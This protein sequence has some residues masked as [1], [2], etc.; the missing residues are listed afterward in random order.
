MI[1]KSMAPDPQNLG[2]DE[3]NFAEFPLALLS[4]RASSGV[5]LLE[6][7]DT[8]TDRKTRLPVQRKVRVYGAQNL[9]LPTS[10][11]ADV[12]IALLKLTKDQNGCTSRVVY[13]SRYGLLKILGWARTG[14]S[15]QRLRMAIRRWLGVYIEYERA[16]WN[17]AIEEWADVHFHVL[18]SA[19]IYGG[20]RIPKGEQADLPYSSFTWNETVF[21]SFQAG[22]IKNLDMSFYL[23]LQSA[24]SKQMYRFLDKHFWQRD[25]L[26]YDLRDFAFEHIG[27]SRKYDTGKIKEKLDPHIRELEE[28]EFLEPMPRSERYRQIR[29]GEWKIIL[30]RHK[31]HPQL[32][33]ATEAKATLHEV[34]PLQAQ[35]MARGIH[36]EMARSLLAEYPADHITTQIETFDTLM[37][38]RD[39]RVSKNPPGWLVDAIRK[40]YHKPKD[41]ATPTDKKRRSEDRI[42]AKKR[43][44][45]LEAERE[46]EELV[47]REQERAPLVAYW[48]SLSAEQQKELE[49][50]ALAAA[51]PMNRERALTDSKFAVA[52]KQYIIDKYIQNILSQNRS[53]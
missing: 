52:V 45:Q 41:V 42:A 32:F 4:D 36:E 5:N 28:R 23:G 2:K 13:F 19:V 7:Q 10:Q 15:Y 35:L 29:P 20:E 30:V 39:K 12:L 8:I 18:E 44:E 9:G 50:S 46:A 34:S 48:N 6:F 1:D 24:I 25:Q 11:D 33:A 16:W 53:D 3:M 49:A 43:A 21:K 51:D 37:Q 17:P 31:K 14:Q 26:E 40:N 22:Y 47:R 27:L 38:A